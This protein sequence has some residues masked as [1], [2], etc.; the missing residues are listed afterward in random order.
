MPPRARWSHVRNELHNDVGTGL[1]KA[2]SALEEDNHALDGVLGHIDF[3]RRVGR[4]RIPDQI[5]SG[6]VC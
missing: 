3:N 2:L 1:N 6:I 5:E 4:T